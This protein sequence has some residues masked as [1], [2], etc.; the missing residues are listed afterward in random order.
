MAQ[1]KMDISEYEALKKIEKNLEESLAN[2]RVLRQELSDAQQEIIDTAKANEKT[3]TI[4]K[5]KHLY[6]NLKQLRPTKEIVDTLKRM[7]ETGRVP[8]F[9]GLSDD[10]RDPI[11]RIGDAFFGT[12]ESESLMEDEQ[13][14]RVGFDEVKA[15]V[16]KEY[17][18]EL[19]EETIRK[20]ARLESTAKAYEKLLKQVEPKD[21]L[22]NTL[23]DENSD[24]SEQLTTQKEEVQRLGNE[25]MTSS[26]LLENIENTL[27][28]TEGV[29]KSKKIVTNI[30][31]LITKWKSTT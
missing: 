25:S 6:Q 26:E 28:Y 8:Q 30:K 7:F 2:E 5:Q 10:A 4:I 11:Q 22:I 12:W 13:V 3:V 19:S 15:E 14:T 20:I 24:L 16:E 23:Q 29:F 1:I 31:S 27:D 18:R 9:F 21:T 17:K